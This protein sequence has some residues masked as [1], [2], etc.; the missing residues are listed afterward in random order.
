MKRTITLTRY[1]D[2]AQFYWGGPY[3]NRQDAEN[4]SEALMNLLDVGVW[5]D[6][7]EGYCAFTY[8]PNNPGYYNNGIFDYFDRTTGYVNIPSFYED[9]REVRHYVV[10]SYARPDM[11][12]IVK[13]QIKHCSLCKR[14]MFASRSV[15]KICA[16]CMRT[17]D[18][19]CEDYG[20]RYNRHKHAWRHGFELELSDGYRHNEHAYL[21]VVE[22]C[23][24]AGFLRTRDATV[25]DEMKSPIYRTQVLPRGLFKLLTLASDF[26]QADNVGTHINISGFS[27]LDWMSRY[28][29]ALFGPLERYLA[30]HE[31]STCRI[32]GR[33][34]GEYCKF[35][36]LREHRS[37][38][39][40]HRDR[41]EFR[42][43]KLGDTEQFYALYN[44][45]LKV[46]REIE[47]LIHTTAKSYAIGDA[48]LSS[49]LD[50]FG[51][52]TL[53]EMRDSTLERAFARSWD[54]EYYDHTVFFDEEY[55]YDFSSPDDEDDD[56]E[57]DTW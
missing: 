10:C 2:H 38:L 32:W 28:A 37:W 6:T 3:E 29:G 18:Y 48:I 33:Y 30:W 23:I 20:T 51:L 21:N 39:S 43:P 7:Q 49:Y 19:D 4:V 11:P 31:D 41:L 45:L 5:V 56:E 25:S 9:A 46:S 14:P 34:F 12:E 53:S 40:F 35:P 15:G 55:G 54:D 16:S 13:L 8:N 42:L 26:T 57:G 27:R 1:E 52:R 17:R 24:K 22:R 47:A 36:G 50:S 44:W